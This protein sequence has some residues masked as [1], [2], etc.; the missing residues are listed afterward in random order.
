MAIYQPVTGS[1][2]N[3]EDPISGK[4]PN[5]LKVGENAVLFASRIE[6]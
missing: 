1:H 2:L 6:I 3:G 5:Y 4:T